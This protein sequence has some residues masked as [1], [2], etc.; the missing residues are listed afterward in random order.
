MKKLFTLI[1]AALV[2]VT[3]FG[4][5]I[6]NRYTA[7][8]AGTP[9]ADFAGVLGSKIIINGT[10]NKVVYAIGRRNLSG[11]TQTHRV[12][13]YD[14]GSWALIASVTNTTTGQATG[15]LYSNIPP[16]TLYAGSN[17][18]VASEEFTGGDSFSDITTNFSENSWVT[19]L[20]ASFT[21][22]LWPSAPTT[23]STAGGTFVGID[24]LATN[25]FTP[26]HTN[27]VTALSASWVDVSNAVA[28]AVCGDTVHIPAG[29]NIWTNTLVIAK[30]ITLM[31]AGQG[32]TVLIDQV[33]RTAF[34]NVN[35]LYFF[36][37]GSCLTRLTA[38]SLSGSTNMTAV[39][40]AGTVRVEGRSDLVRIDHVD[41]YDLYNT[42]IW[43]EIAAFGVVDHC[44]FNSPNAYANCADIENGGMKGDYGNAGNGFGDHSWATDVDWGSTNSFVYFED[45]IYFKGTNAE[46]AIDDMGKGARAVFRYNVITNSYFQTHG[47]ESSGRFRGGRAVEIYGNTFVQTATATGGADVPYTWRSGAAAVYS[48]TITGY[49]STWGLL[50][51]RNTIRAGAWGSANGRNGWDTNNPSVIATGTHTAALTGTNMLTDSGH[52]FTTNQFVGGYEILNLTAGGTNDGTFSMIYSNDNHNIWYVQGVNGAT[53]FTNGNSYS[54]YQIFV[55]LDQIGRGKGDMVTNT[56][57][58][59]LVTGLPTWP[60]QVADPIYQWSN[61]VDGVSSYAYHVNPATPHF[62]IRENRDFYNAVQKPAYAPLVYPHP[63]TGATNSGGGGGAQAQVQGAITN[64]VKIS[65]LPTIGTLLGASRVPVIQG[66]VTMTA[67]IDQ[68]NASGIALANS[69]N[70]YFGLVDVTNKANLTTVSNLVNAETILRAAQIV[71]VTNQVAALF[72]VTNNPVAVTRIT[73]AGNA[74]L[75]DTNAFY[76]ATNPSGFQTWLQASNLAASLVG[77]NPAI[78]NG[79]NATLNKTTT[80]NL[81]TPSYVWPVAVLGNTVNVRSNVNFQAG[82]FQQMELQPANGSSIIYLCPTNYQ[83]GQQVYVWLKTGNAIRVDCTTIAPG[84]ALHGGVHLDLPTGSTWL[85]NWLVIGTNAIFSG[86][87]I[88]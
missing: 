60:N 42:G 55:S 83:D 73:G 24:L 46:A 65:A 15:F 86:G 22:I 75:A 32:K 26:A 6:T 47:T 59:N 51:H 31:G 78:T 9:R 17:Y 67:T 76:L 43:F 57:P 81:V 71:A 34:Q 29:T 49:R 70:T 37:S 3:A 53:L 33:Y 8:T 72:A 64:A 56:D 1:C 50:N 27:D 80:T 20:N 62:D 85:L 28:Y 18:W 2:S 21:S 30:D 16:V 23:D 48:N 35:L 69:F 87:Q 61:T 54:I 74:I 40:A 88:Q 25:T 19:T 13:I 14:G 44:F 66:G 4:S 5:G 52:T 77:Q 11:S 7:F 45:N 82:S 63:L 36:P 12:G 79:G 10:N 39:S 68:V 84:A 41:F 58:I 38:L